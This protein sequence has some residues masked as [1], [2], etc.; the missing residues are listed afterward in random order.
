MEIDETFSMSGFNNKVQYTSHTSLTKE[1]I[2]CCDP[3]FPNG[4]VV[5]GCGFLSYWYQQI[6]KLIQL[7]I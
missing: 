4:F 5:A 2:T 1:K 6:I 7:K 3:T